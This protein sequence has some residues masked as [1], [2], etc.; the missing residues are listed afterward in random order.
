MSSPAASGLPVQVEI[1]QRAGG[2][3][4]RGESL[5][6]VARRQQPFEQPL[7]ER[8]AGNGV[9]GIAAQVLRHFEPML[10]YLRR[11]LDKVAAH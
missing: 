6:E 2:V 9:P 1:E 5:V 8:L 10:E 3:F 11:E 7:G 4:D